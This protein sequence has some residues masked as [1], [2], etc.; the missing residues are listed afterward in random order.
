MK[1]IISILAGVVSLTGVV[2]ADIEKARSMTPDQSKK[3]AE[4]LET[5]KDAGIVTKYE[6]GCY[7]FD[8]D[9]IQ[10]LKSEGLIIN[11]RPQVQTICGGH[12]KW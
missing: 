10:K 12:T 7:D 8:K 2:K 3:V 9:V 1:K 11:K 5:L 6:N 4:A